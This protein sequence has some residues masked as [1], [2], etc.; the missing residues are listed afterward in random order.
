MF[1]AA[2]IGETDR[3][4]KYLERKGLGQIGDT[5]EFATLDQLIDQGFRIARKRLSQQ[6]DRGR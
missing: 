2:V 5:V 3:I 4:R 6:I 1:A